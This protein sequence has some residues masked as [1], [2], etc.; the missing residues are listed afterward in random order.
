M[1][2]LTRLLAGRK[3]A[4]PAAD[5]SLGAFL[6]EGSSAA[7]RSHAGHLHARWQYLGALA[8]VGLTGA[9]VAGA[10]Y[11]LKKAEPLNAAA[12]ASVTIESDP[13]GAVV[14]TNGVRKGVTPLTLAVAPGEYPF[15]VVHGERRLQIRVV[16]RAEVALVHH[17]QFAMASPEEMGGKD[18]RDRSATRPALPPVG[19]VS[20]RPAGA[21]PAGPPAGWLAVRSEMPLEVIEQG[22]VIGSTASARIMLPAGRRDLRLVNESL[23]FAERRVVQVEAGKTASLSVAV[24]Q[25]PISINAVPWAEV[26]IDGVRVGE[27][28]IGN[29]RVGLGSREIVFRHPVLG[30]RRRTAVVSLTTPARMSVDMRKEQ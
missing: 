27:T 7:P 19:P 18:G 14:T 26:W 16:A 20:A 10:Y 2:D 12:A 3:N 1:F 4:A 21:V 23:G 15:E 25:A 24:P 5:D 17:V 30:E 9:G 29:Y 11:L 6:P 8:L 22:Q 13:A 28:P